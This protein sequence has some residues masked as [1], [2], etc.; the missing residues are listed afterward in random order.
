MVQMKKIY[1]CQLLEGEQYCHINSNKMKISI[2]YLYNRNMSDW[3][4]NKIYV[5]LSHEKKNI[6]F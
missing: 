2:Y 5:S 4:L 6:F 1:S 3:L